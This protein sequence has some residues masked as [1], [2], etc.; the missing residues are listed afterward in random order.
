VSAVD[1]V[2]L[3]SSLA[4]LILSV[5]AIWLALHFYDKS[6]DSEKQTEVN[7]NE[8]KT[9]TQALTE[10]SS[11]MLD[12]YTDYATKPKE[13]DETFLAVVQLLSQTTVGSIGSYPTNNNANEL[14]S[15][16]VNATILAM[17]YAGFSNLT[18]QDLLPENASMIEAD[19]NLPN[20][21]NA[22]KEDFLSLDNVL[23]EVDINTLNSSSLAN[24][25]QI[26]T[27][28][29]GGDLVKDMAELYPGLVT[30]Q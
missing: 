11:R 12:K 4:S 2:N 17:F 7:V 19:N 1:I 23:G 26:A 28:W 13:A 16:A 10:I 8:I 5:I 25:Y 14:R 6:K 21:L 22:S 3:I 9:Q 20:L 30:Q 24:I 29:K 15:F 18:L 27:G